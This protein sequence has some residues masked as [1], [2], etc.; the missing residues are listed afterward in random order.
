PGRRSRP[1]RPAAAVPGAGSHQGQ[2]EPVD[3]VEQPL[4]PLVFGDPCARLGEQVLRDVDGAGLVAGPLEGQVLAGVPGTA[5]V[6]AAGGPAGA[7]GVGVEGGGQGRGGGG[8]V[9]YPCGQAAGDQG[10]GG[11]GG[12]ATPTRA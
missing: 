11:R 5:V 4:E 1:P 8:R 7:G 10:A 2:A 9:L 6:T 12:A 3:L